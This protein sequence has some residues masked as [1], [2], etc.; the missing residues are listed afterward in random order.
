MT[1]GGA[2]MGRV[3]EECVR[4]GFSSRAVGGWKAAQRCCGSSC[5]FTVGAG[6]R[7]LPGKEGMVL[8]LLAGW[9]SLPASI[10]FPSL[11]PPPSPFCFLPPP[12]PLPAHSSFSH[13][14][15]GFLFSHLPTTG[16]PF[17]LLCPF[18]FLFFLIF[19]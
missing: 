11:L 15:P 10:T 16:L 1:C 6:N 8:I 9:E 4:R 19:F 3:D 2:L 14:P 7:G 17:F 12:S 5:L 18:L 13:S